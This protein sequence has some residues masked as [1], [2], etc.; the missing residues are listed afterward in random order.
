LT[1]R[2]S[3]HFKRSRR[4]KT[5]R[6]KH[7]ALDA[8]IGS[9]SPTPAAETRILRHALASAVASTHGIS[10]FTSQVAHGVINNLRFTCNYWETY[11]VTACWKRHRTYFLIFKMGL[12]KWLDRWNPWLFAL[13]SVALSIVLFVRFVPSF[14]RTRESTSSTNS[15]DD[16]FVLTV[17][18]LLLAANAILSTMADI[19]I[20]GR[21]GFGTAAVTVWVYVAVIRV[22]VDRPTQKPVPQRPQPD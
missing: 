22:A 12:Q 20:G 21:Y 2:S 6:K 19:P 5:K 4:T 13:A 14:P 15:H 9:A 10:T 8:V 3:P 1:Q 17:L 16:I 11:A 18:W 7:A